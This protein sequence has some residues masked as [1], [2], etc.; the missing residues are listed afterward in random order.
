MDG[1]GFLRLEPDGYRADTLIHRIL[2]ETGGFRPPELT[3]QLPWLTD[4]Y[5]TSKYDNKSDLQ[6]GN[7]FVMSTH[8]RFSGGLDFREFAV[9]LL[10][11]PFCSW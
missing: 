7:S 1:N 11:L 2:A 3:Q 8:H 6:R 10:T 9:A 5:T 4:A